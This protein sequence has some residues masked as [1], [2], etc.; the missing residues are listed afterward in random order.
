[1][2]ASLSI[3]SKSKIFLINDLNDLNVLLKKY[4]FKNSLFIANLSLSEVPILFRKK[5]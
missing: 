2:N 1:M 4:T 5:F 3:K